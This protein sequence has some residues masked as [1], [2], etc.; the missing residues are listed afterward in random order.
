MFIGGI[1]YQMKTMRVLWKFL[2]MVVND[3]FTDEYGPCHMSLLSVGI[4]LIGGIIALGCLMIWASLH[5]VSAEWIAIVVVCILSV[6]G[7]RVWWR[8]L[9]R[10]RW[11]EANKF[12]KTDDT[13]ENTLLRGSQETPDNR[14]LLRVPKDVAK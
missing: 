13:A 4:V 3:V 2:G 12:F 11:E 7:G 10:P 8:E 6:A 1:I 5:R 14:N 9:L